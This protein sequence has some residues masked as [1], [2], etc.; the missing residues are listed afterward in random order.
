MTNS[1]GGSGISTGHGPRPGEA[2]NAGSV[3]VLPASGGFAPYSQQ[4][5]LR[6]RNMVGYPQIG[7]GSSCAIKGTGPVPIGSL[8]AIRRPVLA[9]GWDETCRLPGNLMKDPVDGA[10]AS[11][12]HL[13]LSVRRHRRE[14]HE[15]VAGEFQRLHGSL[16]RGTRARVLPSGGAWH[17]ANQIR[18]RRRDMYVPPRQHGCPIPRSGIPLAKNVPKTVTLGGQ[19]YRRWIHPDQ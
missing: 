13:S 15:W 7:E 4:S 12:R 6:G 18:A 16:H 19:A 17:S 3:C 8:D 11:R 1:D 5:R 14:R 10:C 2:A 9:T